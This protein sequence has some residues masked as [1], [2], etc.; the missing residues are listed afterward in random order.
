MEIGVMHGNWDQYW[1][2]VLYY[3]QLVYPDSNHEAAWFTEMNKK[4]ICKQMAEVAKYLAL[5]RSGK[6]L[7]NL[8]VSPTVAR[9]H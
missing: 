6:R 4:R 8:A 7:G 2:S 9:R 5:R 3:M 1:Q